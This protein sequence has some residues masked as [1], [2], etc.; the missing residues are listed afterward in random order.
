MIQSFQNMEKLRRRHPVEFCPQTFPVLFSRWASGFSIHQDS[1]LRYMRSGLRVQVRAA[2]SGL[3]ASEGLGS[4]VVGVSGNQQPSA[5]RLDGAFVRKTHG[6]TNKAGTRTNTHIC[7][8]NHACSLWLVLARTVSPLKARLRSA[9]PCCSCRVL[10]HTHTHT[11]NFTNCLLY[12]NVSLR[13][14]LL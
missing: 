11:E 7:L 10:N 14:M 5:A 6:N 4:G 8:Q 13:Q 9:A 2:V 1:R 3:Q 12:V